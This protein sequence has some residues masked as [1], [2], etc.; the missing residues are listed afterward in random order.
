MFYKNDV[1]EKR[2]YDV[3]SERHWADR[4]SSTANASILES[5]S[6]GRTHTRQAREEYFGIKS[7]A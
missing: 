5:T 4:C 6:T 1:S 3:M 2:A 7:F